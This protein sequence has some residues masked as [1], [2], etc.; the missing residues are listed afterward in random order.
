MGVGREWVKDVSGLIDCG[1][2]PSAPMA[3][4]R[5]PSGVQEKLGC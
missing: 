3:V 5:D 1:G 2:E 4:L